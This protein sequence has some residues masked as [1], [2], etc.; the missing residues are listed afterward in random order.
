MSLVRLPA[1]VLALSTLLVPAA[2]A[3]PD[4][5]TPT[6]PPDDGALQQTIDPDQEVATDDVVL[7]AGHVDLG[8]RDVD[9]AWTLMVHDD[10][11]LEG[12][13]WRPLEHA[14]IRVRDTGMQQVPDDPAYAFLGVDPGTGVHV[15]PQT[16]NPEVVWLGW[17]TQDPSVLETVDRGVTLTLKGVDGPGHLVVYLQD[18]G[19]GE[20]DVL[21]DSRELDGRDVADQDLWVDVNTHTHANWVFSEPGVHL[22]SI[23]ATATLVDGT[24]QTTTGTLRLAVG[25]ATDPE[26]ARRAEASAPGTSGVAPSA[27]DTEA[28]EEGGTPVWPWGVGAGAVVLVGVLLAV[29]TRGRRTRA[30]ALAD[31]GSGR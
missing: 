20:P 27:A 14:V 13:V 7:E 21:W 17:N 11:R 16:Q 24:E 19:F 23:A 30:R 1:L 28:A 18:G 29:V 12:S 25:D 10:T 8:P 9:G 15:V 2:V 31:D 4:D 22:V 5:P 6:V 26:Q 3:A